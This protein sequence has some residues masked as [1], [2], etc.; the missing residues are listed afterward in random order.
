[1]SNKRELVLKM[2]HFM[3]QARDK[4]RKGDRLSREEYERFLYASKEFA[5][6]EMCDAIVNNKMKCKGALIA[7]AERTQM[8]VERYESRNGET[9]DNPL[10]VLATAWTDAMDRA[11]RE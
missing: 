2:N 4:I 9:N 11:K 10:D 8:M 7:D 3:E 5:A 6:I 1:M